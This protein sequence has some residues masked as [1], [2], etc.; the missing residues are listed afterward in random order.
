M[1]ET[2]LENRG[3]LDTY[4]SSVTRVKKPWGY[5]LIYAVTD[6]YCGKLL[7]V[8]SG[9]ALSLQYHEQ[10]D[11]TIYLEDGLAEIE[12]GRLEE[13]LGRETI[14]PGQSFRIEPGTVHRLRAIKDC[15]FLE[16]STPHLDD[17]VRLEDAYGRADG[18]E[19]S[20]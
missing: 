16:V 1:T 10:K 3:S 13:H 20:A 15:V 18:A 6:A 17:V 12:I 19:A 5:E 2:T 7:Y 11:E 14:W 4:A 9:H 8:R